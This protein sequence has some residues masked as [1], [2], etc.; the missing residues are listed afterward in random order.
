M[1][2]TPKDF[3]QFY[4]AAKAVEKAPK[5]KQAAQAKWVLNHPI[6]QRVAAAFKSVFS[7][8]DLEIPLSKKVVW[9]EHVKIILEEPA[10]TTTLKKEACAA[11]IQKI[12][13]GHLVRAPIKAARDA[14]A[15]AKSDEVTKAAQ[16]IANSH[17]LGA[18]IFYSSGGQAVE[19]RAIDEK[20]PNAAAWD[21]ALL[22]GALTDSQS[23]YILR[24]LASIP[25]ANHPKA[26]ELIKQRLLLPMA[27][28]ELAERLDTQIDAF[29]TGIETKGE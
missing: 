7:I 5:Y 29:K 8:I 22:A 28:T 4:Y 20:H 21:I 13:R 27:E 11:K 25:I 12:A 14:Q 3:K 2:V 9:D 18:V 10:P 19:T 17:P 24:E 23:K 16:E 1:T 26:V 15:N 6:G